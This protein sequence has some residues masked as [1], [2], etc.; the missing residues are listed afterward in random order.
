LWAIC[1]DPAKRNQRWSEQEFFET[2]R[3]E[4]DKM[5]Q[6]VESL[7]LSIDR[8]EIALDFGCG[9]GRLTRALAKNF[10]ECWGVDI[11][12][13]MIQMAKDL[14]RSHPRCKFFLN[15]ANHLQQFSDGFFGFIYTSI[16]LQHIEKRYVRNYLAELVRVLKTGGIFVFQVADRDTS[17]LI[18][19]IR[20]YVGFRSKLNRLIKPNSIEAYRMEMHCIREKEIRRLLSQ[21]RICILDVNFTNSTERSFDGDLQYLEQEPEQGYVSKQYCVVKTK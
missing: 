7:G 5:L 14:H 9:V 20:N 21:E 16:V 6:H 15:K 1:A 19:R 11:S 2:G 10:H 17:G 18:P 3:I 12:P 8:N 4:I 13:T